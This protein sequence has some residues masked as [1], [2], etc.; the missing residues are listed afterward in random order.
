MPRIW[1]VDW[2]R[3]FDIERFTRPNLSK[4]IG[5]RYPAVLESETGIF[6]RFHKVDA[7]GLAHRDLLS[8]CYAGTL[9]VPTLCRELRAKGF[10][11][12][13]DFS[14]WQ[15]RL[16]AWL[17]KHDLH[18]PP[19]GEDTARV[20]EDPPLPFFV[21]FEA[22]HHGGKHLGP[23]GSIIVAE[24]ILGA[25]GRHPLGVEASGPT[26]KERIRRC[27]EMLFGEP[28]VEAIVSS[29]L[30]EID[31]IETMPQLLAYMRGQRLFEPEPLQEERA[32]RKGER[33]WIQ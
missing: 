13:E 33:A 14:V 10:P 3:F 7:G 22:A 27:G 18:F 17:P 29:T 24:T 11:M 4:L 19:D 6:A 23:V 20:V 12:V 1:Q 21:L 30:A 9:S 8:A 26:L 16:R 31:E 15:W 28:E 5:P 25:V 2:A 32:D